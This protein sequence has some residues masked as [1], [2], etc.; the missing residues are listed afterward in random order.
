[1]NNKK[2]GILTFQ[3]A[4]NFGA[5]LQTYA[6]NKVINKSNICCETIDY[7]SKK[8]KNAYKI[9]KIGSV[10][11]FVNSIIGLKDNIIKKAK[12]K[13]F[14]KKNVK[15]SLKKYNEKNI[16]LSNDDYSV[17]ITGSDQVWNLDLSEDK[18]YYLDFVDENRNLLNSYAASFGNINMIERNKEYINCILKKYNYITV[19]EK[20]A[21]E[22]LDEIL[23]IKSTLVLDPTFLLDKEDWNRVIKNKR[24]TK[25]YILLYILHEEDA[26]IIANRIHEL[27]GLKIIV[28]NQSYKKRIKAKYIRNAGPD[29]F[30]NYIKNSEYVITDSFHGTALSIIFRKNLK[31]VLKNKNKHL[32]D[33]L[34]SILKLFD[35]NKCIVNTSSSNKELILKT[36]YTDSEKLIEKEILKSKEVLNKMLNN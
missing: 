20:T 27:T 17:F 5:I 21:Q 23:K 35:L 31:V 14:L 28:L 19:R 26:Y 6:L 2:I 32:N 24:K 7:N 12:F 13:S 18:N 4:V 9:I 33:R 8:I 22:K 36:D 3:N 15:M 10:N 34:V 29:E 16:S 11:L 1:M 30:L 25:K